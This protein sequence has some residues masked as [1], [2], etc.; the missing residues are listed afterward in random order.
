MS[1]NLLCESEE[2][3]WKCV[4]VPVQVLSILVYYVNLVLCSLQPQKPVDNL[5]SDISSSTLNG[6]RERVQS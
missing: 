6:F 3:L 2:M 5:K 4:T 1:Q